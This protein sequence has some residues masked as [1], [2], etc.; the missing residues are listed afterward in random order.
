MLLNLRKTEYDQIDTTRSNCAILIPPNAKSTTWRFVV[1]DASNKVHI[2][3]YKNQVNHIVFKV[4]N[5]IIRIRLD[6]AQVD[7]QRYRL[8]ISHGTR[9]SIYS[10]K[11]KQLMEYS[12]NIDGTISSMTSVQSGVYFVIEAIYQKLV[13]WEEKEF[14]LCADKITDI[15]VLDRVFECFIPLVVISCVDRMLRVLKKGIVVAELEVAGPPTCLA[16]ANMQLRSDHVIYGTSDGKVGL[17]QLSSG[18]PVQR[19]E[20]CSQNTRSAVLS[21]EHYDLLK[22]KQEQ[23]IVAYEDGVIEVY[24]YDEFGYPTL[25]YETKINQRL[26]AVRAGNFAHAD[27][28]ELVCVTYSGE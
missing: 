11:G 4:R 27:F 15:L 9:I 16:N 12:S 18:V 7:K 23:L 2:Y 3:E 14:L 19:W 26:T 6:E 24:T 13:N 1:A 5:P 20:L 8:L 10:I 22:D 21:L 28:P 17:V 25:I